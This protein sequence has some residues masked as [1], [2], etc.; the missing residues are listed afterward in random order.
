MVCEKVK[1]TLMSLQ[2]DIVITVFEKH[3]DKNYYIAY[4]YISF[5]IYL[6][7]TFSYVTL[8]TYLLPWG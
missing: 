4:I 7:Y 1:I 3:P 2:N 5:I 6:I 8:T